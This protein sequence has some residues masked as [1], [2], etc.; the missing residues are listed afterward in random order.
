MSASPDKLCPLQP[1]APASRGPVRALAASASRGDTGL[2]FRYVLEGDL[3]ALRIPALRTPRRAGELWQHTC[4]E[5]FVAVAD[6]GGYLELNFSP[7]TEWAAYG[8]AGYRAGR[9]DVV[10]P[11]PPRIAVTRSQGDLVVDAQVGGAVLPQA[12][13]ATA[14]KLRIALSAVIEDG[15]GGISYW[16]LRHAPGKPDF[17][18]AD[19]F[20]I[21]V[22]T[23]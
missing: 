15:S 13:R 22:T 8:F 14:A 7:S 4:F 16:A 2:R 20:C 6:G 17:H 10:L 11:D 18:H 19:G 9:T 1:F 3:G 12:W 5:A 23:P 21:E